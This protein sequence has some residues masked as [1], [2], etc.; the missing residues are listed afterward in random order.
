MNNPGFLFITYPSIWSQ[1][2]LA[3]EFVFYSLRGI[4]AGK[5]DQIQMPG[6]CYHDHD[7]DC[8]DR[9]FIS[10]QQTKLYALLQMLFAHIKLQ[11]FAKYIQH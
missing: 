5:Q 4:L 3:S 2:K 7:G 6:V 10:E 1:C 9:V 11:N 8:W